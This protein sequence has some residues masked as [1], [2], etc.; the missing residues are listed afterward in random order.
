MNIYTLE[1]VKVLAEIYDEK[2]VPSGLTEEE[3][4]EFGAHFSYTGL[5][6]TVIKDKKLPGASLLEF[7]G[8]YD[9]VVYDDTT[10]D[11]LFHFLFIHPLTEMSTHINDTGAEEWKN[12]VATWRFKI[13]K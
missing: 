1:D 6:E 4:K 3:A 2:A 8:A 10:R 13:G 7:I 12:K 9:N 5:M 11:M